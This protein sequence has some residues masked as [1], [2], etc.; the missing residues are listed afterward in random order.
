MDILKG[1]PPNN[2]TGEIPNPENRTEY[3][4][5]IKYNIWRPK[6]PDY[7]IGEDYD[8]NNKFATNNDLESKYNLSLQEQKNNEYLRN[9]NKY[10][11]YIVSDDE[12][13][14]R[15]EE[16]KRYDWVKP[17]SQWNMTKWW[18]KVLKTPEQILQQ[19]FRSGKNPTRTFRSNKYMKEYMTYPNHGYRNFNEKY[20]MKFAFP[21]ENLDNN[22]GT[23]EKTYYHNQ[24]SNQITNESS[25]YYIPQKHL[26]NPIKESLASQPSSLDGRGYVTYNNTVPKIGIEKQNINSTTLIKHDIDWDKAMMISAGKSNTGTKLFS[27]NNYNLEKKVL[28]YGPEKYVR[29]QKGCILDKYIV[30]RTPETPKIGIN[31][32]VDIYSKE[33]T[34]KLQ[35]TVPM[36]LDKFVTRD[37]VLKSRFITRDSLT[38]PNRI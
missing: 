19:Q 20:G 23:S 5:R 25:G 14:M 2:L 16:V 3:L 22:K 8:F 7:K 35:K 31:R 27:P 6:R 38:N 29:V 37:Y 30:G 21:A 33:T 28:P 17:P 36:L 34:N 13:N 24:T 12:F 11:S 4:Q 18:K 9:R 32:P 26:E 10:K 1:L 15:S